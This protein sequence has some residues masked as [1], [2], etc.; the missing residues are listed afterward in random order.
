MKEDLGNRRCVPCEGGVAPLDTEDQKRF[1]KQL[2][3]EWRVVDDGRKIQYRFLFDS[4]IEA[5][6]FVNDVAAIA[7]AEGHHP[8]I[9]VYYRQVIIDL[10]THAIEGLSDNDFVL[11]RKIELIR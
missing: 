7:E 10:T 3:C 11:A 1:L 6:V 9:H 5:M 8:D 4:F 2:D